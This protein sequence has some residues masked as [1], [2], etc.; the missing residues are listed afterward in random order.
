[1]DGMVQAFENRPSEFLLLQPDVK[2]ML[3]KMKK[4]S[5][6]MHQ[7]RFFIATNSDFDHTNRLMKFAYGDNWRDL[8]DVVFTKVDKKNSFFATNAGFTKLADDESGKKVGSAKDLKLNS[9][10]HGGNAISATDFFFSG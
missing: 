1:M 3:K 6:A 10:Y 8:F 7:V 9:M 5:K 4:S 2:K